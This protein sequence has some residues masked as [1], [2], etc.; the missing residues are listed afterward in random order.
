MENNCNWL[1]PWNIFLM[2][3]IWQFSAPSKRNLGPLVPGADVA[4]PGLCL[5]DD[6]AFWT[7]ATLAA[8]PLGGGG[9]EEEEGRKA[10]MRKDE[11]AMCWQVEIANFVWTCAVPAWDMPSRPF[12]THWHQPPLAPACSSP[13][14]SR[15]WFPCR[16][17]VG[18]WVPA[19][20]RN[21]APEKS[22]CY[23]K[24]QNPISKSLS[25]R[26]IKILHVIPFIC[27]YWNVSNAVSG[28]ISRPFSTRD[29]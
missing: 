12:P 6:W 14:C 3:R 25:H 15:G 16:L 2:R 5:S 23:K 9:A 4:A 18:M 19:S 29:L 11:F 8:A 28:R 21:K 10:Q 24:M 27:V 20:S 22:K 17:P 26:S 7:L 1:I 13:A